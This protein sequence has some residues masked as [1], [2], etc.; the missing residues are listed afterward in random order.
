[1]EKK[2]ANGQGLFLQAMDDIKFFKEGLPERKD[3]AE[4]TAE[5]FDIFKQYQI[6]I[7]QIVYKPE[8]GDFSGLFKYSTSL[9]IKGV[10][11]A[12]KALLADIQ[13]SGN[14]FCI[15]DLSFTGDNGDGPVEMKVKISTYFR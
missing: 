3:F 7:G 11:P 12:L 1:M 4:T 8:S 13:E 14:L 5:L 15:E 10:Y 6:D 2:E 9:S